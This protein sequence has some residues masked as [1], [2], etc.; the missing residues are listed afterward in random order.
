[1]RSIALLGALALPAA[2]CGSDDGP[3]TELGPKE[4]KASVYESV[5][6]EI[7]LPEA[8]R[9]MP[10]TE[11]P[12]VFLATSDGSG[13]GLEVQTI[14]ARDLKDEADLRIEDD[15]ENVVLDDEEGRPVRDDGLLV[16]VTPLPDDQPDRFDLT[17]ALYVDEFDTSTIDVVLNR[18]STAWSVTTSIPAD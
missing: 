4:W 12:I 1:V 15:V 3:S 16:T 9:S 18:R 7:A 8:H 17:V 6:R 10:D 5:L 11:K 13:I 2:A 14:I